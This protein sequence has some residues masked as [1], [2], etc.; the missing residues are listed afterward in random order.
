MATPQ[1]PPAQQLP[2]LTPLKTSPFAWTPCRS[3]DTAI[4]LRRH[5]TLRDQEIG[6]L[7]AEIAA[8][9]DEIAQL[10]TTR[11]QQRNH[12]SNASQNQKQTNGV[13]DCGASSELHAL[14]EKHAELNARDDENRATLAYV[15]SHNKDLAKSLREV[16]RV[17]RRLEKELELAEEKE[18]VRGREGRVG[19]DGAQ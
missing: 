4:L 19:G 11:D 8:R 12:D 15:K 3:S 9:D 7:L 14:H 2:H 5:I 18:R 6:E 16:R 13:C 10:K 17:N 1:T